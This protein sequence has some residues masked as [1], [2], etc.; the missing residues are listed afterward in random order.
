MVQLE[1]FPEISPDVTSLILD[2]GKE[3]VKVEIL[4]L[5]KTDRL[6]DSRRAKL[7]FYPV[8][9]GIKK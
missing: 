5:K 2:K 3:Y 6:S 8:T 7:R 9:S 1:L 4:I